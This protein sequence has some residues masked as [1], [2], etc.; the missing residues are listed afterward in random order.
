MRFGGVLRV[1]AGLARTRPPMCSLS[2]SWRGCP[3]SI[4]SWV[5]NTLKMIYVM[6]NE[7]VFRVDDDQL[8]APDSWRYVLS[9]HI[10]Y[11]AG[12]DGLNSL[13]KHIGA[14]N[15]FYKRLTA[16]ANGFGPGN[17]RQPFEYW[18]L[19]TV[20]S[21]GAGGQDDKPGPGKED[22]RERCAAASLV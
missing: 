18:G 1:G 16:L 2:E 12:D 22:L 19:C 7:M 3:P 8:N 10:S 11:F 21:Q 9:R 5:A 20:R 15:P 6:V 4:L 13:L 17:P 14:E